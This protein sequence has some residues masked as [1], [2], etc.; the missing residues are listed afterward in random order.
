MTKVT[1]CRL[2]TKT[3]SA[4][5]AKWVNQTAFD[6]CY[7]LIEDTSVSELPANNY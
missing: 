7:S 5:E 6:V 1:Q 4:A 2:P 3:L